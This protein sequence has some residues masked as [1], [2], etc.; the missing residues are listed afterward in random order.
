[1]RQIFDI[2]KLL[3][4]STLIQSAGVYTIT[5]ALN[6]AIPFLLM[7]VLTRYLTTADYGMVSMYGV[8]ISFVTPFVGFNV[9]GAV[10]RQ[11]YEREQVDMTV[12]VSSCFAILLCSTVVVFIIFNVLAE[13][14]FRLTSVPQQWLWTIVLVCFMQFICRMVLVLWQVRVMP[15]RYGTF[16]II[17]TALNAGLS[18]IL[19]VIVGMAWQGPLIGQMVAVFVFAGIALVILSRDGWLKFKVNKQ[20]IRSAL[21]FGVPLVPHTLG[22]VIIGIT[23]RIFITK[24]VGLDATG[25][26]TVGYQV[27][28]IIALLQDSFNKAYVPWLYE[29]LKMD[30]LSIKIRLVKI[31]YL[32]FII[33]I[34]ISLLLAA[35]APW[36]LSFFVGKQFA[37]SAIF[38]VWIALGYAFNGMYKMVVNYIFYAQKT[39]IL[40][41]ITF[42]TALV[43]I[44]FNYFFI[45]LNGAIGAAQATTVTFALSFVATWIFSNKAYKMPWFFMENDLYQ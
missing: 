38:V 14:L 28:M 2:I 18:V 33:I 9:E 15:S 30:D 16:Q 29:R 39:A 43:N 17:Q 34:S 23:D 42:G 10:S 20:Y 11:Y 36:F 41:W 35:I 40:A 22:G 24:M 44:V 1:L 3:F 21:N 32:Y 25:L 6:A 12:Y 19:V 4:K 26:Y 37:E 7:P 31:T 27:G 5:S 13:P 45:S 8:L